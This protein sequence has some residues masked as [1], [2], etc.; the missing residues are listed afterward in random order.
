MT[1][2]SSSPSCA[3]PRTTNPRPVADDRHWMQRALE[4]AARGLGNTWPNPAVGCVIVRDGALLGEGWTQPGGRPHAEVHALS[5]I[6]ASGATAFV[7]LEPCSHHGQ[8]GPCAEALIAAGIARVVVSREDPDPRVSGRG[9]AML[10]AAGVTIE[11]GLE[12]AAATRCNVGFISRIERGRPWLTLKLATSLDGRIALQNGQSRWITGP[13]ARAE[14]HR[15]RAQ[16]DGIMIG[17]GTAR[18]DDPRLDVREGAKTPRPPV[19]IVMD[20]NL[21][22][23]ATGQL[24]QTAATQ[25]VGLLHGPQ[26]ATSGRDHPGVRRLEVQMRERLLD[27]DDAL[28]VLG[29]AGLTRVLCEGGGRLAASLLSSGLV[30]ELVLMMAGKVIGGDGTAA[31]GPMGAVDLASAPQL[32]LVE[33]R[34]LGA[35]L[36]SRWVNRATDLPHP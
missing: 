8:T 35:D 30:D 21:S 7:T 32:T 9:C 4:L 28:K 31:V 33:H 10:K 2:R 34:Q 19:R 14:V 1:L 22:T 12:A 36:M 3:Q 18:A 16:S 5:D 11:T 23:P 20:P 17:A 24:I 26:A 6:D 15:M 27:P 25:P 13:E 29:A